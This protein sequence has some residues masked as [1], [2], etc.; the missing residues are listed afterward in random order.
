MCIRDSD[1]LDRA[2]TSG[3]PI[4]FIDL[5]VDDG[6]L[7][8]ATVVGETAGETINEMT[9]RVNSKA[10]LR[11]IGQMIRPYPTFAESSAKAANEALREQY[12][13]PKVRRLTQPV[14]SLLDRVDHAAGSD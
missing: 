10:K 4:G 7:V 5:F 3:E 9:L 12:F 1:Q 13:S 2:V 11:D 8:G 6:K 14:L